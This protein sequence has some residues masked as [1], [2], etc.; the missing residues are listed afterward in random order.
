M[1]SRVV[2]LDHHKTAL[3]TLPPN[4]K[5]PLNLTIVL[6]MKRSGATI[7]YDYFLQSLRQ[8]GQGFHLN[9]VEDEEVCRVESLFKYIEDADLWSWVLPDSKAFSSGLSDSRIE[10]NVE[11]NPAVFKQVSWT[12]ES[13]I[14]LL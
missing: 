1:Q 14:E 4:G 10:Y 13:F 7:S 3:E 11:K 2:V 12:F 9:L 8:R 5:G 6:D